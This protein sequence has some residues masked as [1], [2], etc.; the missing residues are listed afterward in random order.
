MQ[1]DKGYISP[2]MV[3]DQDRMEATLE[4]PYICLLYT[5]SRR[6]VA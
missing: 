2:Y 1:F 6:Q 4:D 3:T 5:S